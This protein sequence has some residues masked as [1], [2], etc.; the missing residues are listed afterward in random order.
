MN[1]VVY[2]IGKVVEIHH[3]CTICLYVITFHYSIAQ[4]HLTANTGGEG[5]LTHSH[6]LK[7]T[8]Y[9]LHFEILSHLINLIITIAPPHHLLAEIL[10]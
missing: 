1:G 6:L 3:S 4:T 5:G 7:A 8:T 2:I 10:I 9:A